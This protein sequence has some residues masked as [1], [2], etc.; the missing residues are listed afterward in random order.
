M[1]GRPTEGRHVFGQCLVDSVDDGVGLIHRES[2]VDGHMQ[3]G[4]HPVT[5]PPGTDFVDSLHALD[6]EWRM[7]D[8][9]GWTA[10]PRPG[11][12]RRPPGQRP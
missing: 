8:L 9:G 10:R 6:P 12:A 5:Q 7:L 3:I 4:V 1:D 11:V 2:S